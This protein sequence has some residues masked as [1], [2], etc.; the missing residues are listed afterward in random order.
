[1]PTTLWEFAIK[2]NIS[3]ILD[4]VNSKMNTLQVDA[5]E[6]EKAFKKS[7]SGIGSQFKYIGAK[8]DQFQ[9]KNL[10]NLNK[11]TTEIPALEKAINFASNP[12]TAAVAG[13]TAIGTGLYKASQ[14]AASFDKQMA[15]VNVTAQLSNKELDHLGDQLKRT[16][17]NLGGAARFEDI[18][19]A[20]NKIISAGLNMDNSLAALEPTLKAAKAGFADLE[21]VAMAGVS[22]LNSSG[23][24]D[25]TKVYD[26]LFATLN[27]G[28]V[29]FKDIAQYLPKII[30]AAKN[31]GIGLEDVAGSFAF[32]T[33]QGQSAESTTTGLIN[34][35]KAFGSDA[36][37]NAFKKIGIDVFDSTGKMRGILPIVED[38]SGKLSTLNSDQS[39]NT[40]FSSLGLDLEASQAISVLAQDTGKLSEILKFTANSSGQLEQAFNNSA[41][42]TDTWNNTLTKLSFIGTEIGERVLPIG[43]SALVG[44]NKGLDSAIS[45]GGSFSNIMRLAKTNLDYATDSLKIGVAAWAGYRTGIFLTTTQGLIPY[46]VNAGRSL[47]VTTALGVRSTVTAGAMRLMQLAQT[48][49]NIAMTA[50]PLG[51]LISGLAIVGTGLHIAYQRSEKF[52]AVM[53]GIMEVG[54]NILPVFTGLGNII[55]GVFSFDID[56]ITAGL[57]RAVGSVQDIAQRGLG[58]IFN[59]GYTTSILNEP[60]GIKDIGAKIPAPNTLNAL[61]ASIASPSNIADSIGI[62]ANVP[63]SASSSMSNSIASVTGG[64]SG[65]TKHVNVTIDR[66]VENITIQSTNTV[67]TNQI[68]T[69]IERTLVQAVSDAEYMM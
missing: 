65:Q 28:N 49:L 23:I 4:K 21:T 45:I 59:E 48:G 50:N 57:S 40:L 36:R 35:V 66:L 34:L 26:V 8:I 20:F 24:N 3:K 1:M 41:N 69:I 29:E 2:D 61:T 9:Q 14:T 31:I 62:P 32:M 6:A 63:A 53:A 43:K 33:A 10:D 68:R 22:V 67:D 30:P 5:S 18:P 38:L 46:I 64:G 37:I 11:L 44:F 17:L 25:A 27:K 47:A 12:I 15:K 13:A 60:K 16:A 42:S 51:L 39:K 55:A 7:F 54:K 52:R 56:K 58:N 19:N